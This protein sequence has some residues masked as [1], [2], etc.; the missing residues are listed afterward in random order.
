MKPVR[1]VF[2]TTGKLLRYLASLLRNPRRIYDVLGTRV[3]RQALYDTA[4]L[5]IALRWNLSPPTLWRSELQAFLVGPGAASELRGQS[6]ASVAQRFTARNEDAPLWLRPGLDAGIWGEIYVRGDYDAPWPLPQGLRVLD[7]GGYG[8]YF[9][10]WVLRTWSITTLLSLEPDPANVDVL[11]WNR[12]E[13]S[14]PRWSVIE[15]AASTSAG[16]ARFAGSRGGTSALRDDGESDVRTVDALPL[17]RNCDLAKIDIEGGEW[18]LLRDERFKEYAPPIIVLEYHPAPGI[19][20]PR[21]DAT[22]LLVAAGYEVTQARA[23]RH[24]GVL[25]ARRR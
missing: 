25:W 20:R 14:D 15:A 10:R 21:D 16:T 7:L 17:L 24:Q 19:E 22:D 8:G 6:E 2:A 3:G 9:G 12:A 1:A 13:V 23:E 18:P 5:I 11:Q 4:R